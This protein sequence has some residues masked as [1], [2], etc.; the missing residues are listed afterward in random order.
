ML[1]RDALRD[2]GGDDPDF[3]RELL[4]T[5]IQT[6]RIDIE[7]LL[8]AVRTGNGHTTASLAHRIKGASQLVGA[9]TLASIADTIERL[10]RQD[11]AADCTQ[12]SQEIQTAFHNILTSMT[13][14]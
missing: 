7:Q 11:P 12:L 2:I 1:N 6:T 8:Q 3:I 14:D 5:F 9:S 10:S 13:P 4:E